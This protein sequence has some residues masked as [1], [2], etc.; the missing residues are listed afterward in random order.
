MSPS[1]STG[2]A[3]GLLAMMLGACAVDGAPAGSDASPPAGPGTR[4]R[5]LAIVQDGGGLAA[6]PAGIRVD[7]AIDAAGTRASG[8][9][10]CNRWTAGVSLDGDRLA[11]GP[12]AA[13]KRLCADPPGV[14]AVESAFLGALGR[15]VQARAE[16]GRLKLLAADG[17]PL[18]ELEPAAD[19]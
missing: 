17:A 10:G 18:L 14:M 13:S 12:A 2:L 6:I 11:F 16:G 1:R 5:A 8:S 15:V 4:W 9:A 19:E 3:A 7:L